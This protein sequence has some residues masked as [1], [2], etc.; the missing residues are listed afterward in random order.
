SLKTRVTD[1]GGLSA[2][3]GIVNITVNSSGPANQ[4]PV[5]SIVTP[6]QNQSFDEGDAILIQAYV[7]DPENQIARVEFFSGN[8]LIGS[9][10]SAPYEINWNNAPVGSHALKTRV[11][12][13]G[14]LSAESGLVNINVN[15]TAQTNLP[16]FISIVTPTNNQSF[17]QGS[18]ILIQSY[19]SDPEN[20]IALVEF[21]SGNTVIGSVTSAPYQLLVTNVPSGNY[22]LKTRV[23]D[24]GGLTAESSLV[25]VTVFNGSAFRTNNMEIVSPTKDQEFNSSEN[26][27]VEIGDESSYSK[28]DSLQVYV[29]GMKV[30]VTK[31]LSYD[32]PLTSV[33]EGDNVISVKAFQYG[34]ELSSDWVNIKVLKDQADSQNRSFGNFEEEAYTFDIGPNPTS[35]ILN[36]YLG[37]MY[38]EEE[39]EIHIYNVNGTTL[40]VLQTNTNVGKV[41]INV[42]SYSQGVYFI[43]ILGKVFTYDTKRFIKQ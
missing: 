15:S 5:T 32:L 29:R 9:V 11:T 14:G 18:D 35:D 42:S 1:Q 20:Q 34:A 24:Q 19:V 21:F 12:D 33:I 25:N 37:K 22:V 38:Q 27:T 2:E 8:T 28:Y 6:M 4:P 26:I 10:T 17:A 16:P 43:R 40:D 41:T 13:Q 7:A 3:S 31:E 23:T 36:I 39:V 30:G